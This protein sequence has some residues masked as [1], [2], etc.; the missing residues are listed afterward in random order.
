MFFQ[1]EK[2]QRRGFSQK[3]VGE[4]KRERERDEKERK[5][6]APRRGKGGGGSTR[7]RHDVNDNE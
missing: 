4:G 6:A 2:R 7:L 3:T 1:A 5:A